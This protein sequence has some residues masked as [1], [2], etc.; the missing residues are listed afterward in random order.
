MK[1]QITRAD[2]E[3]STIITDKDK[4]QLSGDYLPTTKI[5]LIEEAEPVTIAEDVPAP[6]KI[7]SSAK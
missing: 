2:G 7:K 1:Y 6:K 4:D 5:E 3:Q